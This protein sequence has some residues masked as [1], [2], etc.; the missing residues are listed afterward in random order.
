MKTG[1]W[2]GIKLVTKCLWVFSSSA[3]EL[4]IV[5]GIICRWL[6]GLDGEIYPN[7]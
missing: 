3:T 5:V 6:G 2:T 1:W 4:V 7:T